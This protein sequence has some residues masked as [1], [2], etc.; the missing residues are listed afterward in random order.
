MTTEETRLEASVI[1]TESNEEG[2]FLKVEVV[3]PDD[4]DPANPRP[5]EMGA[6]AVMNF[7]EKE[8]EGHIVDVEEI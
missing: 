2:G 5:C 6:M 3:F 1:F 8:L 4:F 7:F